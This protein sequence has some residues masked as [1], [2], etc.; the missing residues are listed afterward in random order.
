MTYD[1]ISRIQT[2]LQKFNQPLACTYV[3]ERYHPGH[4]QI[5]IS[6]RTDNNH[7]S[8]IIKKYIKFEAVVYFQLIPYWSNIPLDVISLD[9]LEDMKTKIF[10]CQLLPNSLQYCYVTK[11]SNLELIICCSSIPRFYEEEPPIVD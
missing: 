1:I 4:R 9:K 5:V 11:L 8:E 10:V 2:I 3:V 7:P 6:C